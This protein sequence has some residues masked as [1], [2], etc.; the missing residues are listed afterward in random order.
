MKNLCIKRI[1]FFYAE[2]ETLSNRKFSE[3]KS[4]EFRDP[5][6]KFTLLEFKKA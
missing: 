2:L 3:S 5:L 1:K 4:F 6:F